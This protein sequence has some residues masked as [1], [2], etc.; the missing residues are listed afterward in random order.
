M[1]SVC[2]EILQVNTGKCSRYK[3]GENWE[4]RGSEAWRRSQ[5]FDKRQGCKE[6]KR[7]KRQPRKRRNRERKENVRYERN[8]VKDLPSFLPFSLLS[9]L[10]CSSLLVFSVPLTIYSPT[11]APVHLSSVPLSE[12]FLCPSSAVYTHRRLKVLGNNQVLRKGGVQVWMR[13]AVQL[14]ASQFSPSLTVLFYL[15][16]SGPP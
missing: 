1:Q 5:V 3:K 11:P 6:D 15:T 9:S 14:S 10:L 7:D 12:N 16:S 8:Q 2:E 4:S 13:P